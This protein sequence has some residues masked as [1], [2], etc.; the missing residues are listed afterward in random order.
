MPLQSTLTQ[1]R[2]ENILTALN[3]AMATFKVVADSLETPFLK[4]I[5]NTMQ[6]LLNAVQTVKKRKDESSDTGGEL[7][8]NMLKNLGQFTET[9]HKIH[10]FVEAQQEK[11]RI[12][13]FFRQGEMSVLLKGCHLGL[14][15]ALEVF[16]VQ[17]ANL[18]R[19]VSNMQEYAS[20]THQEVLDL[21]SSL[22]DGRSSDSASSISRVFSTS[23]NSSSSLLLLPSEPKIF[24]GRESEVSVILQAFHQKR[25]RI[26]ILGGGGMGKTSLAR[27]VLH[28]PEITARYE[29]HCVFI[30]CDT[31]S[32]SVQLAAL[33]G[34]YV[35]LKPGRNLTQPVIHYFSNNPPCLLVLDN[36]ET[37]WEPTESR[38]EVEKFLALLTDVD[39]LALIITMRGAERPANVQWTHP[40][41]GPLKP[42]P[43]NA[44]RQ[45]FMDI[46][47]D[48]Y[49]QEDIDQ[50]LLLADNIPLVVDLIVHLVDYEGI[51]SVL[52]RWQTEKTSIMSDGYDKRSNLDLSILLSL[53]SPRLA[54]PDARELLSLLSLLPDGLSDVELLQ[55][56]LP[57]DNILACKT[58]LLRTSLAYT[59]DHKRLKALVPIRE[60]V[61]KMHPPRA[62]LVQ[63]FLKY[64]NKLLEIHETY[65][66][67]V[68]GYG[69]G[70][71]IT[72]NFT[73]IQNIL[74]WGLYHDN[75]D[76]ASTIYGICYFDGFSRV[77]GHGASKLMDEVSNLLSQSMDHRLQVH[78][79]TQL[80][81]GYLYRPI[82]NADHL[83]DQALAHFTHFNDP[84]LTCR[85][86]V[87]LANYYRS[88]YHDM[89]RALQF[90]QTGLTLAISTG[91]SKRQAEFL[92]TL[93]W[94]K[95]HTG[96]YHAAQEVV[97]E[98]QRQA[99]ISGNLFREAGALRMEAICLKSLGSY[100]QS[101]SCSNR[102]KY[103]LGLC[104]MAEGSSYYTIMTSQADVHQLKSEYVEARNIHTEILR[105]VSA[106]Q[107]PYQHALALLNIAQIDVE[108][109]VSEEAQ[110][111]IDAANSLFSTVGI[112]AG[113]MFCD[114]IQAALWLRKGDLTTAEKLF[115]K[116]LKF[117]WERDNDIVSYCL[118]RLVDVHHR[119]STWSIIFL[120]YSIKLKKKL[121]THKALQFL[122]DV[123]LGLGDESTAVTLFSVA[124][125]GF[126]EMDVHRNRAE[127]MLRLGDISK[128]EGNI[129]RAEE[130]WKTARPL[131]ERSSQAKQIGFVDER[132]VDIKKEEQ[133]LDDLLY[134]PSQ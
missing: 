93:G 96:D 114:T 103:L 1:I 54:L 67:T 35:G 11:S 60:Y 37:I 5:S 14:E 6:S 29:Q 40:F 68:S 62:C 116:C 105:N 2:F 120:A 127:C 28:H 97:Y 64:F 41:L 42:L 21:I 75:P 44:A 8:L 26:A 131:F 98:S 85:F 38:G 86:Y 88:Q 46:V 32:T 39:H 15:Q 69:T 129:A 52:D 71:R 82:P 13:H 25:P 90:A 48:N 55:S 132:L 33:I 58:A 80:F 63:P 53:E 109:S 113:M 30:A 83:V 18:S 78:F 94:I 7:S 108:I 81:A 79:I 89:A 70:A 16:K 57:I 84:D 24:H 110:R 87:H 128:E 72:S 76:Y 95:W 121:E 100:G 99:K 106:K 45:T 43:Q 9:L 74:L 122:G 133:S 17:D 125:E 20:K 111:N 22:L 101:I 102:A 104:G 92:T 123:F 77:S 34:A 59:D 91:N 124:L 115:Q 126:T 47:D 66:G 112:P 73:N 130:L 117:A 23:K 118:E 4:P 107:D 31:I 3:A 19:D 27:V 36:L 51:P 134:A 61:Q 65:S 49:T 50:I 119:S 12:M 56:K 10:T